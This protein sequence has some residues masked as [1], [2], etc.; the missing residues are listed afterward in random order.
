[1]DKNHVHVTRVDCRIGSLENKA[2]LLL[3]GGFVDCR[4]GSLESYQM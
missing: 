3:V 2:L 4:I 1:M